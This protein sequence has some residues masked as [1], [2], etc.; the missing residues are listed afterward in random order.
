M[1]KIIVTMTSYPKRI[2]NIG[3]A[4]WLL[5]YKQTLPPDEIHL[6]LSMQEFVNLEKDLPA[7]LQ[8]LC[9]QKKVQLHWLSKNTY[10]HKRHEIFKIANKDDCVFL[11]DDDVMYD[12]HLI[13]RVMAI[14]KQH[15]NAIICYNNYSIHAYSGRHIKYIESTLGPGPHVN[16]VRWCGQ[17]MIP[18]STYPK[19]L[20][21]EKILACRDQ[22]SP[23]SDEC[24]V[25]P[26]I[27]LNHIPVYFMGLDWGTDLDPKT[28]KT[29]GLVSWTHQK[30]ANGYE[31]R[32]NWLY[33]VISHFPQLKHIYGQEFK[34]GF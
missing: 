11:I 18:V 33:A 15:P 12:N 5:L 21:N 27:V 28:G 29:S 6:W 1:Q 25:Q 31:K 2:G 26:W 23:I 20:L 3:F 32:D 17:S 10:V 34:Y 4:I 30:D 14:H 22:L 16:K 13:E 8:L 24:W 19:Q 7:D 9:S